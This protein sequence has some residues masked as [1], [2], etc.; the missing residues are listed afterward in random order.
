MHTVQGN[1]ESVSRKKAGEAKHIKLAFDVFGYSQAKI[2]KAVHGNDG[3][4]GS[5]QCSLELM[6]GTH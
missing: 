5:V 4:G 2:T 1:E 3:K 6:A